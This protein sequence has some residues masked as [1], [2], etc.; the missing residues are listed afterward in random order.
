VEK[1]GIGDDGYRD[2]AIANASIWELEKLINSISDEDA[3][4][5]NEWFCDPKMFSNPTDEY[6]LY[7]V[8]FMAYEYAKAIIDRK[9]HEKSI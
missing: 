5:L 9:L 2:E 8:F 4:E 3:D 6:I 1:W 7:S